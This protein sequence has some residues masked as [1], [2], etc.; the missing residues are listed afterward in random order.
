MRVELKKEDNLWD[1]KIEFPDVNSD[2]DKLVA[3]TEI[4][5]FVRGNESLM[6]KAIDCISEEYGSDIARESVTL[7]T[8]AMDISN[9]SAG[10]F[11]EEDKVLAEMPVV[12]SVFVDVK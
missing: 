9:G 5:S 6:Q 11:Q 8:R 12:D 2:R 1:I 4:I 7:F 3:S 10:E